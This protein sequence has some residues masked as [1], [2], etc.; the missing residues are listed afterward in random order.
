MLPGVWSPVVNAWVT[1]RY[2]FLI[3][4]MVYLKKQAGGVFRSG[5]KY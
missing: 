4:G 2:I 1:P 5:W 3:W